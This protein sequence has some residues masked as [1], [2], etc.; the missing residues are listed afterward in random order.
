MQVTD[1]LC[2]MLQTSTQTSGQHASPLICILLMITITSSS[3]FQ[4]G[5][6]VLY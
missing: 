1:N 2:K 5:I 3:V 4:S 6:S